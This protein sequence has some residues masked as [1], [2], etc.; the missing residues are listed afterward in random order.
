[1]E[2]IFLFFTKKAVTKSLQKEADMKLNANE[3]ENHLNNCE[4]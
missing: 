4:L 3:K 1:M 2:I